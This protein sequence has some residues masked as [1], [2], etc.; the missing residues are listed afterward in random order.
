MKAAY[1]D[2][3]GGPDVLKF[4]DA[5]FGVLAAGKAGTYCEKIAI[6]AA[7]GEGSL[8]NSRCRGSVGVDDSSA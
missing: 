7:G 3:F 1:I 5:V 6:G 4:G 8:V 2:Q